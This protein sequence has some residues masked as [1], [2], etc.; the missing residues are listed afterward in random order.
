FRHGVTL[1]LAGRYA[2]AVGVLEALHADG[3]ASGVVCA[4]LG[5]AHRQLGDVKAA[6]QYFNE[7]LMLGQFEPVALAQL[8]EIRAI[9]GRADK[10]RVYLER[11]EQV[12]GAEEV[13]VRLRRMLTV[14]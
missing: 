14:A 9:Q 1:G 12:D 2:D 7:A 6:V 11:L 4:K 13:A 8:A 5:L 10:A 3:P